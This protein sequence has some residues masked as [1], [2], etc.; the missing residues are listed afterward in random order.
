MAEPWPGTG[1]RLIHPH[2]PPTSQKSEMPISIP[3][4]PFPISILMSVGFVLQAGM[5]SAREKGDDANGEDLTSRNLTAKSDWAPWLEKDFPFFSSVLDARRIGGSS[6]KNNLVP[7]SLVLNLGQ[8]LWAAYDT[9]LLRLALVWKSKDGNLPVTEESMST[10]SYLHATRKV[11]KGQKDIP[12][13][14]GDSI[15]ANGIHEGWKLLGTSGDPLVF[16]DPRTP[17][18]TKEEVGKG[19]LP[20]NQAKLLGVRFPKGSDVSLH[21]E[22]HGTKVV[23]TLALREENGSNRLVRTFEL[24]AHEQD[25]AV[26]LST[27]AGATP[28]VEAMDSTAPVKPRVGESGSI[29]YLVIPAAKEKVTV[30]ISFGTGFP[31]KKADS[32]VRSVPWTTKVKT[33]G[34]LSGKSDPYVLDDIPLPLENPWKRNPRL[35]DLTFLNDQ[36]DAAAVAFD[37]DVWLVSG[38]KGDL[39]DVRWSRFTSGLHEPLSIVHRNLPGMD[40]GLFVFDRNGVWR[41]IDNDGDGVADEHRLFCNHFGQTAETREYANSMKLAPDGSFVISKG[42]QRGETLAQDSGKVLRISPDGKDVRTIGWG[43]RQ[44]FVGVHPKTGLVTAS[45]Q[46][47]YYVPSTP[48]HIITGNQYYGYLADMM[49]PEQY[50]APIADPLVWIPHPVNPSAVTQVWAE[51]PRFGPLAGECILIGFNRPEL[52]HVLFSQRFKKPQGAVISISRDLEFAPLNGTMNP[53]DGQLYVTGFQNFGTTATRV[54]GLARL[55]HTKHAGAVLKECT[56]T[57][58]G[59]LLTF[60]GPLDDASASMA[61]AYSVERWNYKRTRKYGSPHLKLDGNPGSEWMN[62]SSVY[63]SKDKKSVFVG[64]PDMKP[65]V[66]QMRLG[67][68]IKSADQIALTNSVYFTP[69]ELAEFDPVKEGFGEIKV[70][71]TPRKTVV[72]KVEKPSI[73]EG[74]RLY[75]M[76]GC[77]ACH[78]VDGSGREGKVGP[79]WKGLFG[80]ERVLTDNSRVTAD[81]DY[82]RESILNPSAK[83]PKE[84]KSV[85]AGM[86]IYEGILSDPQI[87]SLIL[88]IKSLEK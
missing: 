36:G 47:G 2:F 66:M 83:V 49:P 64:L 5:I 67:W 87:E 42:G 10:I 71:L 43:L 4:Y 12:K 77:M 16:T 21:L 85:E 3:K 31:A 35:A 18:P 11:D 65:G 50:P 48:V 22:V 25:F 29:R 75:E 78:S 34:T 20:E 57:Q 14:V 24:G 6:P 15:L 62:A 74:K 37:G 58:Q 80:K 41:I 60:D 51:D 70:D 63:L 68:G 40:A 82:L 56:P 19:P 39:K 76:T 9:D 8:D 84:F 7:R 30:R 81:E 23:E 52:F 73:E 26:A 28:Q 59:V 72:A 17:G 33:S 13:P 86:P 54:S 45:D 61:E 46:E 32:S 79:T 88:F 69:Y 55:R 38:L 27:V 1:E 44:P 53:A